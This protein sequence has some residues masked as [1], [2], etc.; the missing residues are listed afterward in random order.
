MDRKLRKQLALRSIKLLN[1]LI[2]VALFCLCWHL[3]Y[4]SR[5]GFGD[6]FVYTTAVGIL[7]LII[8]LLLER[9]YNVFA[10]GSLRV[11]QLVYSQGLAALL[12]AGISYVVMVVVSLQFINPLPLIGVFVAQVLWSVVWSL[13]ANRL[14]YFISP[15]RNT[16]ILY[17]QESELR[18]LA[19]IKNFSAKFHV[20]KYIKETENLSMLP[21]ALE[22]AEAVFVTQLSMDVRNFVIKL[23]V[24]NGI[25]CYILPHVGDVLIAGADNM[26][27]FSVPFMRIQR[28]CPNVEYLFFKRAFDIVASLIA[29]VLAGPFMLV[30]A[31]AIKLYDHGPVLYKQVRLTKDYKQFNVLKFRSMRTD[32]EKDGVA[33]LATEHDNRITPVGKIIRKIRFDELPQ[34][35]NILRGERGIIET[36]K[37]NIGFSRVVVVNSIS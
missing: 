15:P 1:V 37:K 9:I 2:T 25:Q 33:R 3:F 4:A 26:H 21:E 20:T 24:E 29:I 16:V 5:I 18:K 30:T 14:Y 34:L 17:E 11:S 23:C 28:A 19:E 6:S 31:L 36:T 12:S 32:A 10:V 7:Y 8:L 35:F 13:M 27:T 22:G